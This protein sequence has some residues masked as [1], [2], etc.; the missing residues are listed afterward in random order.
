MADSDDILVDFTSRNA[1]GSSRSLS[2][3]TK[4]PQPSGSDIAGLTDRL[5]NIRIQDSISSRM[6]QYTML[7]VPLWILL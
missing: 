2:P 5:G 3:N 4:S 1:V 7:Q 6:M